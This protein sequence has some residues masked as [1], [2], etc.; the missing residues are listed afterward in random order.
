MSDSTALLLT[1]ERALLARAYAP[2]TISS[3]MA[4]GR[5]TAARWPSLTESEFPGC[6]MVASASLRRQGYS[7]TTIHGFQCCM[8]SLA[9]CCWGW[10]LERRKAL[11]TARPVKAVHQV[12]SADDVRVFLVAMRQPFRLQATLCYCCGLRVSEV[13]ALRLGDVN[14]QS[15]MLT[16]RL[17]KCAKGR[18]IPIPPELVPLLQ[19]QASAALDIAQ[20]DLAQGDVLAGISGSE[21]FRSPGMA[22]DLGNWPLFPQKS[23]VYDHRVKNQVR[24]AIHLSKVERAFKECRSTSRVVTRITPHR[25]RD[26]FAV[27]SLCA[28]VPINVIQMHMGHATLETTAKYL[29]FL[30]TDEGAKLFPGLNLFQNLNKS[31]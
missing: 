6:V 16:V 23:L 8:A 21:Y 1:W 10:E 17:S 25:L 26:A 29:S 11:I 13:A 31:A 5:R 28:G 20:A 7:A 22:S 12:P 4:W 19:S 15:R 30:L 9:E 14:L 18:A 3:Y 2:K 27:H 24:V